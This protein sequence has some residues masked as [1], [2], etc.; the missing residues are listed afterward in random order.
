MSE[1]EKVL[2][3]IQ[4]A[5]NTAYGFMSNME[6][7]VDYDEVR[8]DANTIYEN[9]KEAAD[10]QGVVTYVFFAPY[11]EIEQE[12][13]TDPTKTIGLLNPDSPMIYLDSPKYGTSS[14]IINPV[15]LMN[16]ENAKKL[17]TK[18]IKQN[19]RAMAGIVNYNE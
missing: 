10:A 7:S 8:L 2:E 14:Y 12:F 1:K 5:I 4:D 19:S 15:D 13:E 18:M 16:Y 17:I 3:L 9:I 11:K 6:D